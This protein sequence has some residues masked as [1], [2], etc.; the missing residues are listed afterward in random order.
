M[1]T[2]KSKLLPGPPGGLAQDQAGG[3]GA[4]WG[5]R[6]GVAGCVLESIPH[7]SSSFPA[8]VVLLEATLVH[9]ALVPGQLL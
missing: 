6:L 2:P 9:L 3:H 5:P 7:P 8:A 4:Q 1:S